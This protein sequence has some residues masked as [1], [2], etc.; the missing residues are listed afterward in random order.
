MDSFG[1]RYRKPHRKKRDRQ[2]CIGELVQFDGS[3]HKWFEDRG[4]ECC[5]LV[6]IDDA[7]NRVML[8][9][10]PS[11]STESVLSFWKAYCTKYGIPCAIYTIMALCI[12]T[13]KE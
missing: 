3:D 7:S 9:F 12:M 8:K 11:E 1:T 10:A 5:L 6:A 4:P 2:A 13:L